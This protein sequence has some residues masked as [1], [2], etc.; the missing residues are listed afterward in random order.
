V[1]A[2][3]SQ[4]RPTEQRR[5]SLPGCGGGFVRNGLTAA[6][7][8]HAYC[9]GEKVA[10]GLLV[11]LVLEGQARSVLEPVR[12]FATEVGLPVTL[13]EV[14]LS[15]LPAELLLQVA[16]RATAQGETI[17][18]ELFEV[19]PDMVADAIR[20]A[21]ALGRAWKKSHGAGGSRG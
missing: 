17:H 8:T 11:Q 21:D 7:A 13:A 5:K 14:G 6:P 10:Y 1:A 15:D 4:A 12:G 18:N 9:H 20:A 2:P 3:A 16:A 19:R